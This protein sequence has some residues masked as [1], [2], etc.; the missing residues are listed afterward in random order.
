MNFSSRLCGEYL[1]ADLVWLQVAAHTLHL[2]GATSEAHDIQAQLKSDRSVLSEDGHCASL[3]LNL[4]QALVGL[5]CSFIVPITCVFRL[6]SKQ[7]ITPKAPMTSSPSSVQFSLV[8]MSGTV[9]S[10]GTLGLG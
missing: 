2:S 10:L 8:Q 7:Q 5:V 4:F 3:I 1:T 6:L 9:F